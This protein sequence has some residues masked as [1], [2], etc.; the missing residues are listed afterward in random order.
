VYQQALAAYPNARW[1]REELLPKL[2][3]DVAARD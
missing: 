1:I 3:G 2:E